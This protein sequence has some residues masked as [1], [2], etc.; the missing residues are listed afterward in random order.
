M[1]KLRYLKQGLLGLTLAF[2]VPDL[3]LAQVRPDRALGNTRLESCGNGCIRVVGGDRAES[4]LFHSFRR[5]SLNNGE[6][7]FNVPNGVENI[8]GRVTGN[9]PSRI[10][11]TLRV[12]GANLFLLNPNGILFREGASLDVSG[13]FLATT[14]DGFGFENG[15]VFEA[16]E[17]GNL[18][19]LT[20][21]PASILFN[22]NQT[23]GAI[24]LSSA[25]LEVPSG[26]SLVLVGGNVRLNN[27]EL[28]AGGGRVHIAGIS[29]VGSL[30]ITFEDQRLGLSEIPE[31]IA[32]ADIFSRNDTSIS[33]DGSLSFADSG[34]SVF[35]TGNSFTASD[36]FSIN[37]FD[38]GTIPFGKVLI[39]VSDEIVLD[40][41]LFFIRPFFGGDAADVVIRADTVNLRGS[42]IASNAAFGSSGDITV[43]TR[44]LF[45]S[46]RA[47]L[48]VQAGT[49]GVAGN[50]TVNASGIV[51]LNNSFIGAEPNTQSSQSGAVFIDA[52]AMV[53]DNGSSISAA[54][55][56]AAQTSGNIDLRLD[57]YLLLNGGSRIS[58]GGF[59]SGS[60]GNVNI[61]ADFV[62]AVPDQNS[63]IVA[64]AFE[65]QGG[66][67][68]ITTQ[69]ILG[70]AVQP[71]N[72]PN[73]T[74]DIDASSEFGLDGVVTINRPEDDP[75]Q[76]L[77]NLPEDVVDASQLVA[78][79]CGAGGI[80]ANEN[81][82]FIVTGRGGMP[83]APDTPLN[84]AR[85]V[86]GW[87]D[88][89]QTSGSLQTINA[90]RLQTAAP[91]APPPVVEAQGWMV[92][93]Q[94][95]VVLTANHPE[96]LAY[97]SN[98][99]PPTCGR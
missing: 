51:A 92:T 14:G 21:N 78:Q 54:T 48:N 7:Q 71:A 88:L 72:P 91:N 40:Q 10:N 44:Q 69:G 8:L 49:D 35:I 70:L 32:R 50:I 36:G 3:A 53:L 45:M 67:I 16:T 39:D 83:L 96:T 31:G 42:N 77:N 52:G 12:D 18:L 6:I 29:G 85:S 11:G 61:A 47:I 68:N 46:D 74:N 99:N 22:P 19:T 27:G 76:G 87:L 56:N 55:L 13:S 79:N 73:Q 89:D 41:S 82:E 17:P 97:R 24:R 4:N 34:S 59:N 60:G 37:V 33:V 62:L 64:N 20:G 95:E 9:S 93:K 2:L 23:R 65:G 94:G 80:A 43:Q 84:D 15:E 38:F 25:N 90:P 57:D 58:A 81:S 98:L 86:V 5:F 26:E 28:F 66:N 30:G 75:G 63:D 1:K